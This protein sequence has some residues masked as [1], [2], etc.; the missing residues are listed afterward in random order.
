MI[1]IQRTM[2]EKFPD[3]EFSIAG[4]DFKTLIAHTGKKPTKAKLNAAWLE[5]V[6]QDAKTEYKRKR[7][8]EYPSVEELVLALWESVAEQDQTRFLEVKAKREAI[9]NKYPK[10]VEANNGK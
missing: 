2:I 6:E 4:N 3:V 9:K 8:A 5:I 10:P 1:D 7:K